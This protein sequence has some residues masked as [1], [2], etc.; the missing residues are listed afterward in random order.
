MLGPIGGP[1]AALATA[2]VL[3]V[4][5]PA[6]PKAGGTD[7]IVRGLNFG[8][9]AA[10]LFGATTPSSPVVV[11]ACTI[12]CTT[13]A[14]DSNYIDDIT[15][16][17][18]AAVDVCTMQA[19]YDRVSPA[20]TTLDPA[21][22]NLTAYY[23]T[24]YT[25]PPTIAG[26]ASTGTSAGNDL[27]VTGGR[28]APSAGATVNGFVAHRYVSASTMGV[29]CTSATATVLGTTQWS[30]AALVNVASF[31]TDFEGQAYANPPIWNDSVQVL[32]VT[33]SAKGVCAYQANSG[34]IYCYTPHI[35]VPLS[36]WLLIQVRW[37]GVLLQ[38]RVNRGPWQSVDCIGQIVSPGTEMWFG[39]SGYSSLDGDMLDPL[40]AAGCW[41]NAQADNIGAYL[42]SKYALTGLGFPTG[43]VVSI[44]PAT[45]IETLYMIDYPGTTWPGTASA[46]SS[47]SSTATAG[48]FVAPGAGTLNG[49]GTATFNG[50]TQALQSGSLTNAV[51]GYSSVTT[52]PQGYTMTY[53]VKFT[54]LPAD[55]GIAYVN[56][57]LFTDPQAVLGVGVSSDHGVQSFIIDQNNGFSNY[58]E[59][60]NPYGP[61][62]LA[63][64]ATA[65]WMM[66]NSR[67]NGASELSTRIVNGAISE[68]DTQRARPPG[69]PTGAGQPFIG[70][71]YAGAVFLA[72]EIAA[73]A[74]SNKIFNTYALDGTGLFFQNRYALSLGITAANTAFTKNI[75]ES[76]SAPTDAV[77]RQAI[78]SRAPADNV[79][80]P[81]DVI[82]RTAIFSR[83]IGESIGAPTDG[84]ARVFGATRSVVEAIAAATDAVARGQ[85]T[86]ARTIVETTSFPPTDAVTRSITTTRSIGE[87]IA[88]PSDTV[89]RVLAWT[90][91]VSESVAAPTDAVT[92]LV[93]WARAIAENV[94]KPTDTVARTVVYTR[95]VAET[96]PAPTD[97]V[98]LNVARLRAIAESIG[99]PTDAVAR[100]ITTSRSVAEN[101]AA[102][103]DAVTR[104]FK[105]TR[106]IGESISAP[107]DVVT[108]SETTTRAIAESIA[109]VLDAVTKNVGA[110]RAVAESV[111]APTDVVTRTAARARSISETITAPTDSLTRADTFARAVA[112]ATGAPIDSVARVV[113]FTRAIGENVA[114]PTDV[115]VGIKGGPGAYT[116]NISESVAKPTD[117]LTRLFVANRSV[118]ESITAPTDAVARQ[119]MRAR[120]IGETVAAP[121]DALTRLVVDTRAIGESIAKPTDV[122]IRVV[123]ESRS[124]A[125]SLAAMSDAVARQ[126]GH[127]RDV[128]ENVD[129]PTDTLTRIA[130]LQR[131]INEAIAAC[132][133][134]AS[135]PLPYTRSI[136]ENVLAPF[137]AVTFVYVHIIPEAAKARV[138]G[139]GVELHPHA[140]SFVTVH[141]NT[142][143]TQGTAKP[144]S[145]AQATVHENAAASPTGKTYGAQATVTVKPGAGKV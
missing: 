67:W 5:P 60:G 130:H 81:T 135:H 26:V 13:A 74:I 121:S 136:G 107:T 89:A 43:G 18:I 24:S 113:Q 39:F 125:E 73:I 96:V 118:A 84:K 90:R 47:G 10:V 111:A 17:N 124:I 143:A 31:H 114:K 4:V 45:L 11:D 21:T 95:G 126:W 128:A 91:A 35:P 106:A 112:D 42:Q 16:T 78:R 1:I 49:H 100:A 2:V 56:S 6:G 32:G 87:S 101:I 38:C 65:T 68:W 27:V 20:A 77:T 14:G 86:F 132:T 3:C 104:L 144:G 98:T 23:P 41:T 72:G 80:K 127:V 109:A 140:G 82:T 55:G 52:D 22:T 103:T 137:D 142:A 134:A 138:I 37:N 62:V 97:A 50:T 93:A 48:S 79:A 105:P 25:S 34:S 69:Y 70:V 57:D 76:I 71:N 36:K 120:A 110:T 99:A 102:V 117:A 53:L 9:G 19:L 129:A 83:S 12:T 119:L 139:G 59:N 131:T 122:V 30:F 29:K 64:P 115:V 123:S 94:T 133:D 92:R 15:V 46:G 75:G 108:R 7:V 58:I 63:P 33:V 116:A 88:I 66:I 141:V 85:A 8:T 145:E 51:L 54:S 61:Q 44:D 28:A 40:I